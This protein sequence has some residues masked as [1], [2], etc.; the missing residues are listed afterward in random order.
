[1]EA[2]AKV[3]FPALFLAFN[4]VYWPFLVCHDLLFY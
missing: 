2:V 1:M 4:L 3:S